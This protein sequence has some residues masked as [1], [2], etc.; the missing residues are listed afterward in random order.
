MCRVETMAGRP[1]ETAQRTSSRPS[2]DRAVS[3]SIRLMRAIHKQITTQGTEGSEQGIAA[4]VQVKEEREYYNLIL[5]H[6]FE[7]PQVHALQEPV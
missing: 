4:N 7:K 2:F 3:Q 1:P 6:L 5:S